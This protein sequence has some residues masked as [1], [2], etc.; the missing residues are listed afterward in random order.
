MEQYFGCSLEAFLE[1]NRAT[2]PE[3]AG[4]SVRF[5]ETEEFES[6]NRI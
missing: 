2:I 3:E 6:E 1:L 4:T 5:A